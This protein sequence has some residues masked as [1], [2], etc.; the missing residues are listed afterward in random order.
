MNEPPIIEDS[1]DGM[2]NRV[3]IYDFPNKF[4]TGKNAIDNLDEILTTPK[5]MTGLLNWSLEGLKRLLQNKGQLSDSRT[6]SQMG[7]VYDKKSRPMYYFVRDCIEDDVTKHVLREELEEVYIKYAKENNLPKLSKDMIK[8]KLISE[9]KDVGIRVELKQI[10]K[11]QLNDIEQEKEGVG[12]RPRVYTGIALMKHT[13]EHN[14]TSESKQDKIVKEGLV[15]DCSEFIHARI[16][17]TRLAKN[18]PYN[19]IIENPEML[20]NDLI[21]QFPGY[22]NEPGIEILLQIAKNTKNFGLN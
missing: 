5:A 8:E 16:D 3:K 13:T 2:R 6:A 21:K 7:I 9:C 17:L 15:A 12:L 14:S 22:K 4:V 19:G 18:S 10:R 1:T 20:V 11:K